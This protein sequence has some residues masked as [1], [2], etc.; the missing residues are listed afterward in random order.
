MGFSSG[1]DG[2]GS[3]GPTN[4]ASLLGRSNTQGNAGE[5]K[6]YLTGSISVTNNARLTVSNETPGDAGKL[7]IAADCCWTTEVVSSF[8]YQLSWRLAT[9]ICRCGILILMPPR[10]V[11]IAAAGNW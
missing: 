7:T 11:D 1:F 5:I 9:L 4:G 10:G 8:H 2:P 6:S 3:I